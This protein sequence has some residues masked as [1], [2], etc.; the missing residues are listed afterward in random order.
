M[1]SQPANGLTCVQKIE[2]GIRLSCS[3]LQGLRCRRGLGI[4]NDLRLIGGTN[5]TEIQTWNNAG[6]VAEREETTVLVNQQHYL[7]IV[8]C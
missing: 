7:S 3:I 2:E 6:L 5:L 4:T 1:V 8:L